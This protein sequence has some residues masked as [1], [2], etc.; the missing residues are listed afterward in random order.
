MEDMQRRRQQMA[1]LTDIF[2]EDACDNDDFNQKLLKLM[3]LNQAI[4]KFNSEISVLI[5]TRDS[6][7]SALEEQCET[8]KLQKVLN[9]MRGPQNF[10]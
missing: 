10:Q 3:C 4:D 5:E 7:L 2:L 8:E 6:V 9:Q 1:S